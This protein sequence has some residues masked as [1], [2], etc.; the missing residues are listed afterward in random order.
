MSSAINHIFDILSQLSAR[1][2]GNETLIR[3]AILP[4]DFESYQWHSSIHI[5][6]PHR[7]ISSFVVPS[8]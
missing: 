2:P 8:G 4:L 3:K 1:G 6:G 7:I 5:F